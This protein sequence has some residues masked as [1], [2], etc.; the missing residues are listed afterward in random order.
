MRRLMFILMELCCGRSELSSSH[1]QNTASNLLL[2]WKTK[3]VNEGLRPTIPSN[4]PTEYAKLTRQCF[5]NA[6]HER[7]SFFRIV[8]KLKQL[9]KQDVEEELR[10]KE[11][12]QAEYHQSLT[13]ADSMKST[14]AGRVRKIKGGSVRK[15]DSIGGANSSGEDLASQLDVYVN[16]LTALKERGKLRSTD[17]TVKMARSAE[18]N[19]PAKD[20]PPPSTITTGNNLRMAYS[21]SILVNKSLDANPDNKQL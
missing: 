3:I 8:D 1:T 11:K 18:S 13:G 20:I 2:C 7:P 21:A 4:F 14:L 12:L 6:D 9:V 5:S 19:V 17:N 10:Q 15:K 16:P